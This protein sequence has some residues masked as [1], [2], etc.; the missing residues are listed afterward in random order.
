MRISVVIP[1]YNAARF[2]SDTL[3]SV[4]AQTL[5]VHEIV[6]VDDG[7]ADDTAQVAATF[8]CRVIRQANGGVCAARNTGILAATG[9]W[10]ALLDH[11]DVWLPHKLERQKLAAEL[12]PDV[13][14]VATDF[15]RAR[16]DGSESSCLDDPRYSFDAITSE[17]VVGSIVRLPRFEEQVLD[18]GWFLFPSSMLIRRDVLIRAGM[19]RTEQRLCEDVDCFLRVLALAPLAMV[20]ESLWRWREHAGNT[21]RDFTGIAEGWLRLGAYVRDEPSAYPPGTG[22]RLQPILHAMRRDLVAEYTS[23]GDFANA[24]RVSRT[25]VGGRRTPSDTALAVVVEF[26]PQLWAMLRRARSVFRALSLSS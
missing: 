3:A 16:A 14:S 20:R 7:S 1:A 2:L 15:L 17:V 8:G 25:T 19:F 11:D 6:V 9:D 22:A 12:C 21:S 23:R 5:D 10:I 26:P 18:T 24:R 13:G 4:R